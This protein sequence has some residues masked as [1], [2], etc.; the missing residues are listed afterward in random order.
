MVLLPIFPFETGIRNQIAVRPAMQVQ[1]RVASHDLVCGGG[2]LGLEANDNLKQISCIHTL[3]SRFGEEDEV[4]SA[5]TSHLCLFFLLGVGFS[6]STLSVR[7]DH[8]SDS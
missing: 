3:A 8:D 2:S 7:A 6:E 4:R 1:K 5:S